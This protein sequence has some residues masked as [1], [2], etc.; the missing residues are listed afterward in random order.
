MRAR[1]P[2][3]TDEEIERIEALAA[4]YCDSALAQRIAA[5][6]R[7]ARRSGRSRS[8]TTASSCT[9]ASTSSRSRAR[10]RSSS[11]TRRTSSTGRTPDEV[12]EHDYRLQ[13]LVY[14][15]ACLRAGAERVEVVYQFL[16]RPDAPVSRAFTRAEL[17]E[18]EAELSAAIARD[19]R[20]RV[21]PA[22]SEMACS[23]CPA[24]DVVC[25]GL[26]LRDAEPAF[27]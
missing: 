9:G 10:R 24:L 21:P 22:P 4:A 16:E 18:L 11:T 3:A 13:R 17:P 2:G 27:L 26:R 15:L 1:Y 6:A 23:G 14:A 5:L 8:S 19:Q 20:R 12:I 25:A 7:P